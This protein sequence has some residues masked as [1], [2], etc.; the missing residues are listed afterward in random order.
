MLA[1]HTRIKP[2]I[3]MLDIRIK[4]KRITTIQTTDIIGNRPLQY[5]ASNRS[6][7]IARTAPNSN[8]PVQSHAAPT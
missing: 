5:Q 6:G 7:N 8:F 4:F 1:I 3:F 2:I